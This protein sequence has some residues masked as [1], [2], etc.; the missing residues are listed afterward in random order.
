MGSKKLAR[1]GGPGPD[2]IKGDESGRGRREGIEI[3]G[4]GGGGISG[5]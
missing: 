1:T 2:G 4:E 5:S 3:S